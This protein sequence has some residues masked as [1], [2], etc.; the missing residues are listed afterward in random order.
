MSNIKK[1]NVEPE[2]KVIKQQEEI[3]SG[4]GYNSTEDIELHK[5]KRKEYHKNKLLKNAVKQEKFV[6]LL[7]KC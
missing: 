1:N 5:I 7:L 3:N 2:N 4:N 6:S